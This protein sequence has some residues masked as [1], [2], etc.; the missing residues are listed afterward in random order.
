MNQFCGHCLK[1][2]S[3]KNKR[4]MQ[5]G[6]CS[7]CRRPPPDGQLSFLE[8]RPTPRAADDEKARR[9][10]RSKSGKRSGGSR[11]R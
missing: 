10:K 6:F 9:N 7:V 3:S 8:V 4:D 11:R 5:T 2:L 1:K